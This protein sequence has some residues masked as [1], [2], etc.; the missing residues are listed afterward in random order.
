MVER[1]SLEGRMLWTP[2]QLAQLATIGD[3]SFEASP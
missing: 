1:E 2:W 3:P